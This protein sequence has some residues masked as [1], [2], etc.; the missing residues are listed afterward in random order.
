MN[1]VAAA[2]VHL[3]TLSVTIT[4]CYVYTAKIRIHTR[5]ELSVANRHYNK[6]DSTH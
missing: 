5:L 3:A 1:P 6:V 2:Y 4:Y